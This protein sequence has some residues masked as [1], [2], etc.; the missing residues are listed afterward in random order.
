MYQTLSIF[1]TNKKVI[2]ATISILSFVLYIAFSSVINRYRVVIFD[3]WLTVFLQMR[4]PETTNFA[5]K[6]FSVLGSFEVTGL[7]SG[8][9]FLYFLLKKKYSLAFA[10]LLF[11]VILPIE[12]WGKNF[13]YHPGPP[14]T[15]YRKSF[16]ILLPSGFVRSDFAYPSGH[17][18]RSVFLSFLIFFLLPK[19]SKKWLW[20]TL[21]FVFLGLMLWSRI[22]LGEHWTTDVIGGAL[23]GISLA[24]VGVAINNLSPRS[25]R[26]VP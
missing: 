17:A 5:F 2:F 26:H 9:A 16:N 18:A 10:F 14:E 4:T 20:R 7:I 13:W 25:K 12:L 19:N 11:I 8:C 3:N 1:R 6:I 22:V 15:F 24:A 23:L 21:I